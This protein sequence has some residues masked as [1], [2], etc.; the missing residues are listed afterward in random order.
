MAKKIVKKSED[1]DVVVTKPNFQVGVFRIRGNAA[2][3]QNK[4][5]AKAKMK[6][7]ETQKAGQTAAKDRVKAPKDFLANYQG[8]MHISTEGWHGIP[9]PAFRNALISACKVVGF[10]MTRAKLS[11]FA[12]ADGHDADDGTPLVKITRGKPEYTEHPVRN[13]SGVCDIRARPM[14][15]VGWEA[16]VRIR[17]DAD[18][19]TL[20]D[21]ANL[22]LRAGIQVGVGEGRPDSKK[23]NGMDWGTFDIVN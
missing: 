2:Y 14:W 22:M 13:S 16:V 21:V 1:A 18:Q 17:F 15:A 23:S 6:I 3:V 12:M 10:A 8:A 11:L 7:V 9:A 20:D 4:F 5:S 19:F